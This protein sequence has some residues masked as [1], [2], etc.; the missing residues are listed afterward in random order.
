[1][2]RDT[3]VTE[4]TIDLNKRQSIEE[5]TGGRIKKL[6]PAEKPERPRGRARS[7]RTEQAGKAESM[8]K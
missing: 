5:L 2:Q 1:M 6:A 3:E 8:R 7:G 4:M